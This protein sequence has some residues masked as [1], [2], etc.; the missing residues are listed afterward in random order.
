MKTSVKFIIVALSIP[1]FAACV[2]PNAELTKV[3]IKT[4]TLDLGNG[5][6]GVALPSG[7]KVCYGV[8]VTGPGIA[9]SK[10]TPTCEVSVGVFSGWVAEGKSLNVEVPKGESRQFDL[11]VYLAEA[12]TECPAFATS[13]L[14]GADASRVIPSGKTAGVNL[15]ADSAT[16]KIELNFPGAQASIA[17]TCSNQAGLK[18]KLYS[19]GE[20][21]DAITGVALPG[22]NVTTEYAYLSPLSDVLRIGRISSGGIINIGTN[23]IEVPAYVSSVTRKPDTGDYYG[24]MADGQI[25]KLS[26][27]SMMTAEILN[28]SNCPF[29]A[30]D[31]RVPVWM[32]SISAGYQTELYGLDHGGNI[33]KISGSG[34]DPVGTVVTPN[35][36]QVSYY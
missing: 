21:I 28:A 15:M 1:F 19:S 5:A 33:L 2:R 29:A 36:T 13:Q 14:S 30:A 6:Q 8:N 16:V 18:A 11:F 34:V 17:G 22:E 10:S 32:Q 7:K 27:S 26:G 9:D 20:L 24:L 3:S 12:G 25:V 35:V 23:D 4:P 31:C